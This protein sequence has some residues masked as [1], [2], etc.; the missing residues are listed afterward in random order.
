MSRLSFKIR[1]QAGLVKLGKFIK[2]SPPRL[3][4]F[5]KRG[6]GKIKKRSAVTSQVFYAELRKKHSPPRWLANSVNFVGEWFHG[7]WKYLQVLTIS[8]FFYL[9]VFLILTRVAPQNIANIPFADTYF[10]F[11]LPLL[12]GN[13]F[14][15]TFL[16]QSR[17]L[18]LWFALTVFLILFFRLG[19]F[20]FSTGL[21]IF[22]SV[23]SV[24]ILFGLI[25][26]KLWQFMAR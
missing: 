26:K 20:Y 1:F 9:I 24:L 5:C 12:M 21:V 2:A 7:Y 15:F 17:R 8:V 4:K 22:I 16:F 6:F 10:L 14:F 23:T 3:G 11:Q 19:R 25:G 13:F 18:G